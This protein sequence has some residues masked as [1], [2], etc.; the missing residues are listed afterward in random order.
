MFTQI[1][2]SE[3]AGKTIRS[4]HDTEF[5]GLLIVFDD[6]TFAF[7]QA[8]LYQDWAEIDTEGHLDPIVCKPETLESALGEYGVELRAKDLEWQRQERAKFLQRD[9]EE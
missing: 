8:H 5:G 7:L 1:D 3:S 6:Q 4:V 2:F 9:R